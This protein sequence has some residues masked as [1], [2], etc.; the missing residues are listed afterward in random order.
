[1][2][3]FAWF[4]RKSTDGVEASPEEA[5]AAT[6]TADTAEAAAADVRESG[7]EKGTEVSED[8][9][10]DVEIPKQQSADEA[11]DNEAGESARK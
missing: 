6:L 2:G 5:Q 10:A 7:A 11:A 3:V 9:A 4:R 1:M 8:A